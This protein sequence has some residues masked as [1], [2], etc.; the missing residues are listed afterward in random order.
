VQA[1]LG[2]ECP[3]DMERVASPL[4]LDCFSVLLNV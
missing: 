1:P 3:E 4:S 2:G